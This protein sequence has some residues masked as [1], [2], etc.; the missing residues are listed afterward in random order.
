M[1]D[2]LPRRIR[3][4]RV[5]GWHMPDG[6]LYV[7]RPTIWGNPFIIGRPFMRGRRVEDGR[8]AASLYAGFAPQNGK[9][10]EAA[11]ARLKGLDLACWC[12]L[13]DLHRAGGLPLG[14]R[15]PYCAPCHADTLL[16]IANG[17]LP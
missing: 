11:R 12:A 9:L 17:R 6:A 2:R 5:P 8:H 16:L 10:I 4:Q 15:C 7:G 13:C 3:R 14:E 1:S